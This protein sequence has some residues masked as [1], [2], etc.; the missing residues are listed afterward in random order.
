[1][2]SNAPSPNLCTLQSLR[3][4]KAAAIVRASAVRV[5]PDIR[6]GD[7]PFIGDVTGVDGQPL[8]G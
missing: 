4:A 5:A 8:L 1:M 7:L 2:V 3:Y 6:G